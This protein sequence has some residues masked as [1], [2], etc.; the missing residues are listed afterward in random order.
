MKSEA[1]PAATTIDLI[2]LQG[3]QG[4]IGIIASGFGSDFT[5]FEGFTIQ[6]RGFKLG[7]IIGLCVNMILRDCVFQDFDGGPTSGGALVVVG[8]GSI[9]DSK[10]L[11]CKAN[12]GG[13]MY[14]GD[15]HIN[16]IGCLIQNC[17]NSPV[18]IEEYGGGYP[19]SS[20]IVNCE[21]LGNISPGGGALVLGSASG[22]TI[23]KACLFKGNI[24]TGAGAGGLGLGLGAKTVENCTFIENGAMGNN[25][26]GGGLNA[27]SSALIVRNN[28]FFDNYKTSDPQ[29][30]GAIYLA[31]TTFG[32]LE[33]NIICSSNGGSAVESLGTMSTAC[34][35][36]WDN[37]EGI[38]VPLSPT[39][40]EVD[41]LFCNPAAYDL[42]LQ[43]TS[44]CL[45]PYSLGCGLIGAL[46]IGCGATSA[47]E[48]PARSWGQIKGLYR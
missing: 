23:V 18:Q 21:F 32:T 43:S 46:K 47:P 36:F 22:P 14:C 17:Q 30:G 33:N 39:D 45:P 16:L 24:N 35:V 7:A 40:R 19:V 3:P 27:F 34:N 26:Q 8:N 31:P 1:G 12:N 10:F 38:G 48:M 42:T 37:P 44:P 28:T 25:G 4:A 9:I 20:T 41:P 6:G 2:D 13:A 29:G 11:N 15:G 5:S